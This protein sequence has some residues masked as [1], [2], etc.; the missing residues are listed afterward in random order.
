MRRRAVFL[1]RDGILNCAIIRNGRPYPPSSLEELQTSPGIEK[2]CADL[3]AAGLAL[4]MVTNQPDVARGSQTKDVVAAING[5]LS[6][7]LSL[8]DVRVCY[9]DD[10]DQ[11]LCRKPQP[12]L[13]VQA[14]EEL[15]IDLSRSFMIGDRWKDVEAGRRA[16]CKTVF[17][18]Y[19]YEEK[20]PQHPD[21]QTKSVADAVDWILKFND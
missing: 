21:Y 2:A 1:D 7:R 3:H 18:D 11:C 14:A 4:I 6:S 12:G 10:E 5:S 15:D 17:V 8:D 16:G 19:S 13:L 9:H 20:K